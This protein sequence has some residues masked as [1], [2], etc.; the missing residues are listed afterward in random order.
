MVF[1]AVVTAVPLA[2]YRRT[3]D[4]HHHRQRR[5]LSQDVM[6]KH[7]G[8]TPRR[9]LCPEDPNMLSWHEATAWCC[10]SK[11]EERSLYD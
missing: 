9:S 6:Q 10:G 1:L 8:N 3:R 7:R 2:Y 11:R 5:N 4:F